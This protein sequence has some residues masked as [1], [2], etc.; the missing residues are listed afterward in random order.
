ML[1]KCSASVILSWPHPYG[2]VLYRQ[3]KI[4]YNY[5]FDIVTDYRLSECFVDPEFL[6]LLG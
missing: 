3:V 4:I 2:F 1:K 6:V 5:G